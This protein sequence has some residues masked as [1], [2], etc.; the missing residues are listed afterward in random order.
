MD[1]P[2]YQKAGPELI[3]VSSRENNLIDRMLLQKFIP[4][5]FVSLQFRLSV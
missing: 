4:E 2:H 1:H 3:S 5:L